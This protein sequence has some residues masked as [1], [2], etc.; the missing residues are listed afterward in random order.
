MPPLEAAVAD[1]SATDQHAGLLDFLQDDESLVEK[2]TPT[3]AS[4]GKPSDGSPDAGQQKE[5]ATQDADPSQQGPSK[6][7]DEEEAAKPLSA[8]E[9]QKQAREA[10]GLSDTE[11]QT[12]DY[13]RKKVAA[14]SKEAK[15]LVQW[16]K[17]AEEFFAKE[18][19]LKLVRGQQGFGL[20]ANPE[21]V[22]Q[23]TEALVPEVLKTLTKAEL[24]VGLEKPEELA[25]VVAQKTV[26]SIVSSR[27]EPTT[28]MGEVRIP[29][30]YTHLTLPT[31]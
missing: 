18:K 15:E 12:I 2:P 19:G 4:E 9:L 6:D 30:S 31:N 26:E 11:P 14:S 23:K 10:L 27:L 22:A 1:P 3:A 7:G 17:G 21:Y 24:E 5:K 13:L 8:E 29:V 28:T 25:K 16:R 20:V